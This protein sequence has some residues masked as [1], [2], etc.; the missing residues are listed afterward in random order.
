MLCSLNVYDNAV[1][2][3][4]NLGAAADMHRKILKIC[5]I[6]SG[7]VLGVD[8][9][10]KFPEA[11]I[12]KAENISLVCFSM[13]NIVCILVVNCNYQEY[14]NG[15]KY[16]KHT[17]GR[18]TSVLYKI[19]R[20]HQKSHGKTAYNNDA[21]LPAVSDKLFKGG[22]S[23][24]VKFGRFSAEYIFPQLGVYFLTVSLTRPG[25]FFNIS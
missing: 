16:G 11:F 25:H 18:F 9:I 22:T 1:N 17:P 15:K 12:F 2:E 6:Q 21:L 5:V 13:G 20:Y 10:S 3:K 7:A 8:N 4:T 24:L 19:Y 14:H 23:V